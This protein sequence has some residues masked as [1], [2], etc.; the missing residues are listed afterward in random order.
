MSGLPVYALSVEIAFTSALSDATPVWVDVTDRVRSFITRRGRDDELAVIQP[1]TATFVL[2]NTDGYFD[3]D[4]SGTYAGSIRPNR[5]VRVRA[6][7]L[8]T[9]DWHPVWY[10][11]ADSWTRS[12]PGGADDSITTLEA[13]DR[14]KLLAQRTHTT[15]LV[16][17]AETAVYRIT[18]LLE[19]NGYPMV[20][21]GERA[22]NTDGYA[23]RNL[24]AYTYDTFGSALGNL[25]DAAHG[26]GGQLFMSAAGQFVFQTYAFRSTHTLATTSQ[27]NFGNA[28][29]T[30]IPV[31]HDFSTVVDDVA[32]ANY[33][34]VTDADGVVQVAADDDAIFADGPVFVNVGSTLLPTADAQARA[35]AVLAAMKAA[36]PRIPRVT[37]DGTSDTNVMAQILA[38][39]ISDRITI[40]FVAPGESQ[41]WERPQH[42]EAIEHDVDVAQGTWRASFALSPATGGAV[43]LADDG[44]VMTDFYAVGYSGDY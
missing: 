25:H 4:G 27:G 42:V 7:R 5:P 3:R 6:K 8:S 20:P 23:T 26:D 22:L 40:R 21:A 11:Y 32:M 17:P 34:R 19:N 16:R 12:W 2:D 15:A 37:V 33:V 13:T 31:E 44:T 38:R 14:F 28:S 24:A 18:A 41:G 43:T 1:G 9:S 35:D 36:E 29:S 10:G 39:E 30:D